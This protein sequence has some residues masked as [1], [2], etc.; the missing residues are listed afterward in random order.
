MMDANNMMIDLWSGCTPNGHGWSADSRTT[1][2]KSMYS[3]MRVRTSSECWTT[4]GVLSKTC[5]DGEDSRSSVKPCEIQSRIL[6]RVVTSAPAA[7]SM[8]SIA[9]CQRA[10][11]DA[12]GMA[13]SVRR[14]T[15]TVSAGSAEV[16]GGG[17]WTGS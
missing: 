10:W 15:E 6:R 8:R 4:V 14:E 16:S 1:A 3:W 12:S 5:M 11:T 7:A 9:E 2:P 13:A 17:V